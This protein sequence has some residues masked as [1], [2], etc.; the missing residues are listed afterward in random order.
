[1]NFIS[2]TDSYNKKVLI[3]TESIAAVSTSNSVGSFTRV[4]LKTGSSY[5]VF[6]STTEI[7]DMLMLNKG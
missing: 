5:L 4:E 7:Q 3:D 6:E 1:M 2:L